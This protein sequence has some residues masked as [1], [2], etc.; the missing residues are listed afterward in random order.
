MAKPGTKVE[1]LDNPVIGFGGSGGDTKK[2]YGGYPYSLDFSLS[3]MD[4]SRITISFISEDRKYDTGK[5][6]EDIIESGT[7]SWA[8]QIQYCGGGDNTFYGYPLKYSINRSPRGDILTV[9]YYDA[10]I[11]EL[12][13]C[14][15][16]LNNEDFP[17][18]AVNA[19]E[20]GEIPFGTI[21]ENP[22]EWGI[23]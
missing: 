20:G 4:P 16:V 2:K 11:V 19:E 21:A 3:L 22:C 1:N 7:R 12:D 9:D 15:V 13:N 6:Q 23:F 18:V 5:L 10:S 17:P 8:Q 14:F